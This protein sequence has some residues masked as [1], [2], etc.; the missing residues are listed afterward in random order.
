[1]ADNTLGNMEADFPTALT[2]YS[3][4]NNQQ[5]NMLKNGASMLSFIVG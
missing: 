4:Y 2:Q 5:Q 3:F 1:M